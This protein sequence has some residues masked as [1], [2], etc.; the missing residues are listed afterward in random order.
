MHDFKHNYS[1]EWDSIVSVND[2]KTMLANTMSFAGLIAIPKM[3]P[4][5]EPDTASTHCSMGK[6]FA[7]KMASHDVFTNIGSD[8]SIIVMTALHS[9]NVS[10]AVADGDKVLLSDTH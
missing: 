5:G 6:K 3:I 10:H 2:L 4:Q 7:W 9:T 8:S 1:V